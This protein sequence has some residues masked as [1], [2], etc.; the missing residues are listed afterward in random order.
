MGSKLEQTR[1][2]VR[3]RT[4]RRDV[5][6]LV[7]AMLTFARTERRK[8]HIM[9]K[10][11]LNYRQF[12]RYLECLERSGFIAEESG[13]WK[14]TDKGAHIIEACQMCRRLAH[15]FNQLA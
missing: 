3:P 13:L 10:V 8:S 2:I 4:R 12:V 14:T 5:H 1:A 7:V 11:G 9:N 6:D 15:E